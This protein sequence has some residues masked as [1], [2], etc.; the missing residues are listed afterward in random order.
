MNNYTQESSLIERIITSKFYIQEI[1]G[2]QE[3]SRTLD[4]HEIHMLKY[5]KEIINEVMELLE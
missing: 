3:L 4:D 1:L 2:L 5:I